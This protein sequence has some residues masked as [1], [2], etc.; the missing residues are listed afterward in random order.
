M[1]IKASLNGGLELILSVGRAHETAA[2]QMLLRRWPPFLEGVSG[3]P[4]RISYST[5]DGTG[6]GELASDQKSLFQ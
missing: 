3:N 5:A 1:T 4:N 6:K 2:G